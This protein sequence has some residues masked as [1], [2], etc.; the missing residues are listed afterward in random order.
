MK[1]KIKQVSVDKFNGADIIEGVLGGCQQVLWDNNYEA[2]LPSG[3]DKSEIRVDL[4]EARKIRNTE[5][6]Q[7]QAT[8]F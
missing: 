3:T 2:V 5:L 8:S 6:H 1:E 4:N 7:S